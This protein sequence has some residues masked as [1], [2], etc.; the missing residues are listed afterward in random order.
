MKNIFNENP[1]F[2]KEFDLQ[3]FTLFIGEK[4]IN[5]WFSD[6]R[7]KDTPKGFKTYE[8]RHS[9]DD[10]TIP[11]TIENKVNVNFFGTFITE[12][13]VLGKKKHLNIDDSDFSEWGE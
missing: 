4:E 11:V 13:N 5:G 6:F 9:D 2:A 12:E 1:K 3:P 10:D 7:V 8:L